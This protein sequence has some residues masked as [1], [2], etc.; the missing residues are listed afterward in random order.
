M[1]HLTHLP[2]EVRRRVLIHRRPLAAG[3]AALAVLAALRSVQPPAPSTAQVW[4]AAHDIPA[5]RVLAY[6]DLRRT[7]YAPGS[8]PAG[9]VGDPAAVVGRTLAAPLRRGAPLTD[10]SVVARPLTSAYPG[11]VATPVRLADGGVVDLLRVGDLVDLVAADPQGR[12]A[13]R[14]IASRV[15]VI[16]IPRARPSVDDVGLQGRLVLMAVPGAEAADVAAAGLAGYLTVTL[17]R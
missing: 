10:L 4:T 11:R 5:G 2:G 1:P 17:S 15:A 13:A 12:A 16:A 7:S 9:A 8:V 6:D 14:T 3:L